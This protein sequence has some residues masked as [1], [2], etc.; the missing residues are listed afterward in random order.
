MLRAPTL[1][2]PAR[3]GASWRPEL[4]LP[5]FAV[6][7]ILG[8]AASIS[9]FLAAGSV[10]FV[11]LVFLPWAWLFALL[12]FA[13]Q[14]NRIRIDVGGLGLQVGHLFVIALAA[15]TVLTRR[16]G[17]RRARWGPTE[18]ALIGFIGLQ[19]VASYLNARNKTQS[20]AT[21]GLLA[22]GATAYLVI[23]RGV[24]TRE[25]L[26]LA[27]RAAMWSAL[28]GSA[29]GVLALA[30]HFLLGTSLG[31]QFDP[32]RHSPLVPRGFSFE[33]DILGSFS[34]SAAIA[35]FVLSRESNPVMSRRLCLLGFTLSAASWVVAQARAAWVAVVVVFLLVQILRRPR[36][37]RSAALERAGTVLILVAVAAVGVSW[38]ASRIFSPGNS[39]LV[40]VGLQHRT[41]NLLNVQSGSGA[42]R[43]NEFQTAL[44][45]L[46]RSPLIG[47][48]TNSYG[49]RHSSQIGPRVTK[50]AYLGNLYAR[51]LYDS[52]VIGLLLLVV[53]L[54]TI[55]WPSRLLRRSA[56]D[57]APVALAFMFA[58]WVLA[59]SFAA[60]DASFQL[61]PWI[62]LGLA[63]AGRA[64]ATAQSRTR[65]EG[66]ALGNGHGEGPVPPDD[67][68]APHR[69]PAS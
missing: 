63:A 60:T 47:L 6:A 59:I 28:I 41:G 18:L 11:A 5:G 57:L 44:S 4:L 19:F 36:R 39:S 58:Y 52:G 55:L 15:R 61:W 2:I 23:T 20:L 34:G 22:L 24:I 16:R 10:L 8:L 67:S 46:H 64:L 56:G 66:A 37:Q 49:Q 69:V 50:S 32:S 3:P 53:F 29:G 68:R 45:D 33:H 21:A 12:A 25:R 9:P 7:G 65:A 27:A 17:E 43:V 54:G 62:L 1:S 40:A 51:S 26:I 13:A 31:I 48:G 38:G 30:A 42:A 14:V 35:F